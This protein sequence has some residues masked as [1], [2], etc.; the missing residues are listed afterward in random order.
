MLQP[1]TG[2]LYLNNASAIISIWLCF[3]YT[4]IP[5]NMVILYFHLSYFL[6]SNNAFILHGTM[7]LSFNIDIVLIVSSKIFADI[8]KLISV[9]DIVEVQLIPKRW[10][11]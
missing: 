1:A 8:T 5:H 4:L 3:T 9:S 2:G 7:I 10:P 6:V 11:H